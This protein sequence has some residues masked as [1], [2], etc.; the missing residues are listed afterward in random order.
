[1][2]LI[3]LEKSINLTIFEKKIDEIVYCNNVSY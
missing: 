2:K 3:E 1:M